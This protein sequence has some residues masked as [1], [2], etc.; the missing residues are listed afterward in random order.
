MVVPSEVKAARG[1]HDDILR[2]PGEGHRPQ[3][4]AAKPRP[5][6][7]ATCFV[8]APLTSGLAP[9]SPD[10]RRLASRRPTTRPV[11]SGVMVGAL[12]EVA[13]GVRVVRLSTAE[14]HLLDDA[15]S[16]VGDRCSVTAD[17]VAA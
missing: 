2:L 11:P 8:S 3:S 1:V 5:P 13:A 4:D 17:F 10:P 12:L 7:G 6:S 14:R 15:P 16:R 9:V